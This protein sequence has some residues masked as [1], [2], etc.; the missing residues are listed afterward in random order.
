MGESEWKPEIVSWINRM[1]TL[2]NFESPWNAHFL[3]L[4]LVCHLGRFSKVETSIRAR[5]PAG[6]LAYDTCV[7]LTCGL[8]VQFEKPSENK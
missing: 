5:N 4:I 1:K 6:Y 2:E 8:L 3:I 7:W